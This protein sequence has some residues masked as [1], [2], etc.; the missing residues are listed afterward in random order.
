LLAMDTSLLHTSPFLFGVTKQILLYLNRLSHLPKV[1]KVLFFFFIWF[2]ALISDILHFFHENIDV[3]KLA[4]NTRETNVSDVV[5]FC[6]FFHN[7]FTN[8]CGWNFASAFFSN[9]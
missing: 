2:V 1:E 9:F 4:V 3:L 7:V 8:F 5:N 6:E